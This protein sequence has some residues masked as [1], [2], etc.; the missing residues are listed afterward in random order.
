MTLTP[1]IA[2][3]QSVDKL[4]V[5][6]REDLDSVQGTFAVAFKPFG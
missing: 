6:V 2:S 3:S 1:T 4:R 5:D